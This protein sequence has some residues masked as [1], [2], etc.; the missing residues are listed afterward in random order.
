M[1]HSIAIPHYHRPAAHKQER[2]PRHTRRLFLSALLGMIIVGLGFT[3][4]V[5]SMD[6]VHASLD[7]LSQEVVP[8]VSYPRKELPRE[9]QWN[10]KPV[11]YEFM[12]RGGVKPDRIDWIRNNGRR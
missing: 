8:D 9:W 2:D 4:T 5:S 7:V 10:P 11:K 12:Y 6:A 1:S 3:I